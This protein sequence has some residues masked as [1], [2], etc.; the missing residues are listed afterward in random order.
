M[1]VLYQSG[2]ANAISVLNLNVICF[3][4]LRKSKQ[5]NHLVFGGFC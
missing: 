3:K 2:F 1:F 5:K 4:K